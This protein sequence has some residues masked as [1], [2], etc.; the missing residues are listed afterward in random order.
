MLAGWELREGTLLTEAQAERAKTRQA[1]VLLSRALGLPVPP[2]KTFSL[3]LPLTRH[4][5]GHKAHILLCLH[6][7]N[8]QS[9]AE[10][11]RAGPESPL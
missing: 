5:Q 2:F 11:H 7:V 6:V 1:P 3:L 8:A 4:L 10:A 9:Q